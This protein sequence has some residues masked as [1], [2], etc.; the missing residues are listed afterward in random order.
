MLIGRF[1]YMVLEA[2]HGGII[3]TGKHGIVFVAKDKEI[4]QITNS[5]TT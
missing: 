4:W 5:P 2:V 3:R 1:L